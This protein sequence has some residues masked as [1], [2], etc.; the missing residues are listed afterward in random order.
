MSCVV[1][2]SARVLLVIALATVSGCGAANKQARSPGIRIVIDDDTPGAESVTIPFGNHRN[3]T[4]LVGWLMFMAE[5]KGVDRVSDVAFHFETNSGGRRMRCHT[6]LVR[7]DIAGPLAGAAADSSALLRKTTRFVREHE[8]VCAAEMVQYIWRGRNVGSAEV[9]A[10]TDCRYPI[11]ERYVARYGFQY[12]AEFVPAD[13]RQLSQMY[14]DRALEEGPA[15]CVPISES[16]PM[17]GNFVTVRI[18]RYQKSVP[19]L[20]GSLSDDTSWRSTFTHLPAP[21]ERHIG[22]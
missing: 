8:L 4:A 15:S 17:S 1:T 13:W 18:A 7:G 10:T 3:G 11:V 2:T 19:V 9:F 14:S 12:E 6:S 5:R 16:D 21:R 22:K 20:P